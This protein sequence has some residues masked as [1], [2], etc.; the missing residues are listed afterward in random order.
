M[1]FISKIDKKTWDNYILNLEKKVILPSIKDEKNLNKNTR[2]TAENKRNSNLTNS[3][4]IKKK[5][6]KPDCILDLHGYSLYSGRLILNKYIID[7]YEKNI[8]SMLII[9]GKGFNNKGALKKEVP[10]W[11]DDELLSKYL[12]SFNQAP[13]HFGG[14][15]AL[16]L[17]IKNKYKN[18]IKN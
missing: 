16:L 13:R 9:T 3:K 15:G 6:F 17:R 1:V 11:L 14:E 10:T 12:I 4:L 5:Y 7:C 8:R 2:H 18:N